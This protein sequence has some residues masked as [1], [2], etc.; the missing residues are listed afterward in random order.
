MGQH[1]NHFRTGYSRHYLRAL[2]HGFKPMTFAQYMR[3]LFLNLI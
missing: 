2:R 3:F 1:V